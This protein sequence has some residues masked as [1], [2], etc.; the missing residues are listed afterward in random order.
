MNAHRQSHPAHALSSPQVSCVSRW[1]SAQLPPV[2]FCQGVI[3]PAVVLEDAVQRLQSRCVLTCGKCTV[4]NDGRGP[5]G[6][7]SRKGLDQL[8]AMLKHSFRGKCRTR[9]FASTSIIIFIGVVIVIIAGE[10]CII[11][12]D[13]WHLLPPLT[14]RIIWTFMHSDLPPHFHYVIVSED[15][16]MLPMDQATPP[17][18]PSPCFDAHRMIFRLRALSKQAASTQATCSGCLPGSLGACVAGGPQMFPS[19]KNCLS[20]V[21]TPALFL[22]PRDKERQVP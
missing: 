10:S 7:P 1:H 8:I 17:S 18:L 21:P 6:V 19:S 2:C 16:V 15:L 3:F 11:L 5:S 9:A 14:R 20:S 4:E 22:R 12:I 13:N